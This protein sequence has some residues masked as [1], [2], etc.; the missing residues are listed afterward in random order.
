MP[1]HHD[2]PLAVQELPQQADEFVCTRC[3]LVHH[4]H[5]MA[6]EDAQVCFGCS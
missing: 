4:R 3:A 2:T 5:N 6:D 1:V